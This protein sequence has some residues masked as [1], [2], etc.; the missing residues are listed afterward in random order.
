MLTFVVAASD[1]SRPL[2]DDVRGR[3]ETLSADTLLHRPES[4]DQLACES[5][6]VLVRTWQTVDPP[7]GFPQSQRSPAGLVALAGWS[8]P[9]DGRAPDLDWLASLAGQPERLTTELDRR[10][11]AFTLVAVDAEGRGSVVADRSGGGLLYVARRHGALIVSNRPDVVATV[12]SP[13]HAPARDV[14]AVAWL[15]ALGFMGDERTSFAGVTVLDVD[16]RVEL[17]PEGARVVD[18][19]APW[20]RPGPPP[21]VDAVADRLV[22]LVQAAAAHP[23]DEKLFLL[24]GG[25]DSRTLLAAAV[26]GGVADR[27]DLVTFGTED[28]QD[29][30]AAGAVARHLGLTVRR[31][32]P[33]TYALDDERFLRAAREHVGATSGMF[34]LWDLKG[35]HPT[36]ALRVTG[37][38]GGFLHSLSRPLTATDDVDALTDDMADALRFDAGGFLRPEVR[39]TLRA[40]LAAWVEQELGAGTAPEGLADVY[41]ADVHRRRWIGAAQEINTWGA[42]LAPL[43]DEDLIRSGLAASPEDRSTGMHSLEILRA[44]RPDL[45]T[46]PLANHGWGPACTA[47][48]PEV[49]V[50]PV[51]APR[52]RAVDWHDRTWPLIESVFREHLEAQANPALHDL[53][54]V[55]A[56]RSAMDRHAR[57]DAHT[58]AQLWATLGAAIWLSGTDLP[59]TYPPTTAATATERDRLRAEADRLRG[60]A[61]AALAR[62][63]RAEAESA[64]LRGRRVVRAGLALADS[65]GRARRRLRR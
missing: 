61:A 29:V 5:G 47:R 65:L 32:E 10:A 21:D 60:E 36:W 33:V 3:V 43:L 34:G 50:P 44:L 12:I 53:V 55:T 18:G 56:L 23:A 17:A 38:G 13:R 31:V 16:A 59:V 6:R 1:S 40:R 27:F 25:R 8:W 35:L 20:H 2:V 49:D 64:R 28:H 57:L 11:G 58:K 26:E 14:D 39:T 51:P 19:T 63:E 9:L 54:D 22:R 37:L 15:P 24:S 41:Y 30:V 52:T 45:A 42:Q 48:Y 4:E 46:L 7:T 62:A